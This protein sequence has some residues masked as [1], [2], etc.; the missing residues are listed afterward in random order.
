MA[1]VKN[2]I[3]VVNSC[4][5]NLK[6]KIFHQEDLKLSVTGIVD[7]IGKERSLVSILEHSSGRMVLKNY[8]AGIS[9]H[10]QAMRIIFLHLKSWK[11]KIN[12]VANR[13]VYGGQKFGEITPLKKSVIDQ[14]KKYNKISA[15][16]NPI[17]LSLAV[18]LQEILP[19][20]RHFA[21]FE[22]V[23]FEKIPLANRNYPIQDIYKDEYLVSR[24]GASGISTQY[25][26]GAAQEKIKKSF[27]KIK[28]VGKI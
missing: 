5:E 9:D 2:F 14:L 17:N 16:D 19:N 11:R 15:K 24:Y 10:Q 7:R 18:L 1:K 22:N 26:L 21:I 12:L 8:P 4:P 6:F 3:L 23:F 13:V 25:V 28:I 20:A 27:K